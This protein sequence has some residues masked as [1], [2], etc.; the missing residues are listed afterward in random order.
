LYHWAVRAKNKELFLAAKK[1]GT[2]VAARD[3]RK[4]SALHIAVA[5]GEPWF[6]R[7]LIKAGAPVNKSVYSPGD[8]YA[9]DEKVYRGTDD[10]LAVAVRDGNNL[11]VVQILLDAGVNL[12]VK[13][14][15]YERY[16]ALHLAAMYG[17]L[18]MVEAMIK[19]G[20]N[21]NARDRYRRTPLH[22]AVLRNNKEVVRALINAGANVNA[23][24]SDGLK[25]IDDS[26]GGD[27]SPA[28]KAELRAMLGGS[29]R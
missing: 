23:K 18:D 2:P 26:R 5:D 8:K 13:A 22:D 9:D 11:E 28:D 1:S 19:A 17:W 10:L 24:D 27:I 12:E 25:P 14:N 6:T 7:E 15:V 4:T 16:T 20:A 21:V 29:S 3:E